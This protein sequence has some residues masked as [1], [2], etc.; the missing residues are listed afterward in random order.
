[1]SYES[2][3][4]SLE[5][6]RPVRLYRF[7]L[8]GNVWRF[9]AADHD[10]LTEDG[11]VWKSVAISDSG[12]RQT[13]EAVQDALTIEAPISI[14]PVQVHLT[15]APAVAMQVDILQK[16]EGNA[17]VRTVY[18]GEVSQCDTGG[19]PGRARITCE[20]ISASMQREGLRL[21]WQRTCPYALYDPVTCK[22]DKGLYAAPVVILQRNG[23]Q[24]TTTDH[25]RPD[26]W[27]SGGFMSWVDPT[28]GIEFRGIEQQSGN[29]F[30]VLGRTEDIYEGLTVTMYPGCARNTDTCANKFGNLDNYGGVPGMPGKSP[31]DGDPVF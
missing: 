4:S 21:G 26:G 14:G 6:G 3:E 5:E 23:Y 28:R 29:L 15:T 24:L 13:G 18:A 30:I 17:T 9:T 20:T 11:A 12:F 19:D 1:M 16:H 2:I 31:F 8:S 25:G 22:V 27:F 10:V 7:T